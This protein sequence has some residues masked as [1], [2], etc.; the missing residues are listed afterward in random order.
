MGVGVF[1]RSL[2]SLLNK[3]FARLAIITIV[4]DELII[5][6]VRVPN[7]RDGFNSKPRTTLYI[8]KSCRVVFLVL[9]VDHCIR[10][11]K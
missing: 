9:E 4:L 8:L 3:C 6:S 2:H 1:W 5:S 10:D 11:Y 7:S